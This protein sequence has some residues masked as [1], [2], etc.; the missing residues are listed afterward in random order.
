MTK[1]R[2]GSGAGYQVR[3][4]AT[5]RLAAEAESISAFAVA[6]AERSAAFSITTAQTVALTAAA[7]ES[8]VLYAKNGSSLPLGIGAFAVGNSA[9]GT[10]R[11]YVNTTGGTIISSGTAV[12]PVNFNAASGRQFNG[13]AFRGADGLTQTGGTVLVLGYA[14]T[15][16]NTLETAGALILGVD[17]SVTLTF[18]PDSNCNVE[19][20][21]LSAYS[22]GA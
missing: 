22:N 9:A 4:S 21:I 2:D 18:E 19:A 20:T 14:A 11:A 6:S 1:I 3:V 7:G 10:W 16:F 8:A 15:G 5:N 12:T 17:N 13:D